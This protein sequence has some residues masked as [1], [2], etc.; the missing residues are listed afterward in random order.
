MHQRTSDRWAGHIGDEPRVRD[1]VDT[2]RF[3][4]E[5]HVRPDRLTNQIHAAWGGLRLQIFAQV[6][7][8][9][10]ASLC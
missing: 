4:R 1:M 5:P 2:M 3:L 6:C 9:Q 7:E 8:G 10:L